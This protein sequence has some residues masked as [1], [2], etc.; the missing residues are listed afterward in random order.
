MRREAVALAFAGVVWLAAL[1]GKAFDRSLTSEAEQPSRS[2]DAVKELQT[3]VKNLLRRAL[4]NK[5]ARMTTRTRSRARVR[6][7]RQL[8]SRRQIADARTNV[9]LGVIPLN[10]RR[11]VRAFEPIMKEDRAEAK[12][13][14]STNASARESLRA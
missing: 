9:I 3:I 7:P 1:T 12:N 13:D 14:G 4:N 2:H 10:A 11:P 5:G 8:R 6:P